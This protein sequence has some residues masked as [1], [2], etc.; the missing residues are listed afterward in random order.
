MTKL[1][2]IYNLFKKRFHNI[3]KMKFTSKIII[4]KLN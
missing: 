1:L 4:D 3:L 2:K